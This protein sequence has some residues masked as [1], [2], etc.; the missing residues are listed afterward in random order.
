V[1]PSTTHSRFVPGS[2]VDLTKRQERCD[3]VDSQIASVGNAVLKVGTKVS[4]SVEAWNCEA[5]IN[6]HKFLVKPDIVRGG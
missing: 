4:I 1:R 2:S 5:G 3:Q 6:M